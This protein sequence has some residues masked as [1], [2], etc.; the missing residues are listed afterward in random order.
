MSNYTLAGPSRISYSV[1]ARVL[2]AAVLG[3]RRSPA[4]D[5]ELVWRGISP[6]VLLTGDVDG[7]P[8]GP[9]VIAANHLNGPGIWVGLGAALIAAVLGRETPNAMIR[10]VGV[11]AYRDFKLWGFVPISD[12]ITRFAF[13]RFYVVY[14]IIRMPHVSEGANRRSSAVRSILA[15]LRKGE[16]IILFPEGRNVENFVMREIQP[17]VGDLLRLVTRMDVPVVPI[18]LAPTGATFSLTIGSRLNT[19]VDASGQEIEM[20]LGRTLAAMLPAQLRGPYA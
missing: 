12:S 17:G 11:A 16:V 5:G 9:C 7:L 1:W 10:G 13:R 20:H 18:A 2:V 15:A 4:V 14:G 8:N 19:L 6:P 3:R